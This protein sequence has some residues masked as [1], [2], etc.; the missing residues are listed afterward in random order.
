VIVDDIGWSK[1]AIFE[2]DALAQAVNDA[3]AAGVAF[4]S[5]AGN[6]GF[7]YSFRFSFVSSSL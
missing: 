4:F 1:E 6:D 7:L 3:A 5:A 2:D